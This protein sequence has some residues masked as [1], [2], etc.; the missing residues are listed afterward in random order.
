MMQWLWRLLG[1]PEDFPPPPPHRYTPYL[2]HD[3]PCVYCGGF[4]DGEGDGDE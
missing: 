1:K 3:A 4:H 2:H